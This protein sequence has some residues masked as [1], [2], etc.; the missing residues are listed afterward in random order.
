MEQGFFFNR[1]DIDCAGIA[2][3]KG[4]KFAVDIDLGTADATVSFFQDT[5]MRA[6]AAAD[7]T[8]RQLMIIKS[9]FGPFPRLQRCITFEN[10]AGDV[11]GAGFPKQI[12]SAGNGRTGQGGCAH[13]GSEVANPHRSSPKDN[14]ADT[15]K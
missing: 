6:Y 4:I 2:V 13:V 11:S 14:N 3:S 10:G 1:V 7:A 8:I 12:F 9:F 5:A 15:P